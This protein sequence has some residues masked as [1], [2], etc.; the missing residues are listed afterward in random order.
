MSIF[1]IFRRKREGVLFKPRGNIGDKPMWVPID[2]ERTHYAKS[3]RGIDQSSNLFNIS[4]IQGTHRQG[5]LSYNELDDIYFQS[6]I[7]RAIVDGIGRVVSTLTWEIVST[8]EEKKAPNLHIKEAKEFFLDPNE[9]DESFGQII[10]KLI[11]DL[12]VYDAGVVEKIFTKGNELEH[13]M[14]RQGSTFFVDADKH[15]VVKGYRQQV[16][17]GMD[18]P[19]NFSDEEIMYMS[20]YPRSSSPYG[21]PILDSLNYEVASVL[22][23]L[24][25]VSKSFNMDEIPPGILVLGKMGQEAYEDAKKQFRANREGGRKDFKITVVKDTEKATWV[26]FTRP[27]KEM[28]LIELIREVNMMIFRTFGVTPTEMGA[29]EDINKATA[30]VERDV[31]R[32]NLISPIV[33]LLEWYFNSEIVWKHFYPDVSIV[34]RHEEEQQIEL[35]MQRAREL[36]PLGVLTPNE[37][38]QELGMES[39]KGMG[40]V[41]FIYNA[42]SVIKLEELEIEEEEV[43][44]ET[45]EIPEPSPFPFG[46]EETEEPEVVKI[47]KSVEHDNPMRLLKNN[48]THIDIRKSISVKG[49]LLDSYDDIWERNR[50]KFIKSMVSAYRE[51]R[52]NQ[53]IDRQISALAAPMFSASD[54]WLTMG[55]NDGIRE[56]KKLD[57]T[58]RINS[59]GKAER[60]KRLLNTHKEA[61]RKSLLEGNPRD[62]ANMS[63]KNTFKKLVAAF[64]EKAR[65]VKKYKF[66]DEAEQE[67]FE[68]LIEV[69]YDGFLVATAK[70]ATKSRL[71]RYANK[72][73]GA[74]HEGWITAFQYTDKPELKVVKW[75][76]TSS[77]VCPDCSA[78][79]AGSPYPV[80]AVPTVPGYCETV[81]FDNCLCILEIEKVDRVMPAVRP[82]SK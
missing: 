51:N 67:K 58:M 65:A 41:P 30:M 61:I 22:N 1:D 48:G 29:L 14:A 70:G 8:D 74:T 75:V 43:E 55:F 45:P 2:P 34:F 13:I 5:R 80:D 37:S 71:E 50:N 23:A 69:A 46:F 76:N 10:R 72:A 38:R 63:F 33:T 25:H 18:E 3:I 47:L 81:C 54:K 26:P 64:Q 19:V 32:S 31:S 35:A 11:R 15:G 27:N 16:Q 53:A 4:N 49:R 7:I 59:Q 73:W 6:S 60:L 21:T 12:L 36:V 77:D 20:L 9:N 57:K 68:E 62:K 24:Q 78:L 82:E 79:E 17:G 52:T 42:Q 39:H 56:A 44:E 66:N 40:D 28:Q